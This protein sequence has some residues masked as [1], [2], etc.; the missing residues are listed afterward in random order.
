MPVVTRAVTVVP[1]ALRPLAYVVNPQQQ[2]RFRQPPCTQCRYQ[3][4]RV[5]ELLLRES[6]QQNKGSQQRKQR[7]DQ[8][9]TSLGRMSDKV[10]LAMSTLQ[11]QLQQVEELAAHGQSEQLCEAT[12]RYN[13][14]RRA[15]VVVRQQMVVQREAAG[16]RVNNDALIDAMWPLPKSLEVQSR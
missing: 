13:E 14:L 12:Q 4:A 9:E 16:F 7:N 6:A 3:S 8:P 2:N 5:M 1:S 10:N 15:A 11:L